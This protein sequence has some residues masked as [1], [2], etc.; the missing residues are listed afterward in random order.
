MKQSK[1][2]QCNEI[3]CCRSK[4]K[5]SSCR[6]QQDKRKG[7]SFYKHLMEW[8]QSSFFGQPGEDS[9]DATIL[10]SIIANL[11]KISCTLTRYRRHFSHFGLNGLQRLLPLPPSF[12]ALL[13]PPLGLPLVLRPLVG[14]TTGSPFSGPPSSGSPFPGS[15][16]SGSSFSGSPFPD[17]SFSG[18]GSWLFSGETVIGDGSLSAKGAG[19]RAVTLASA[20]VVVT[21]TIVVRVGGE[22]LTPAPA[23]GLSGAGPNIAG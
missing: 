9:L 23:A 3:T 14:F 10:P 15:S 5:V 12:P 21:V 19:D 13:P 7:L 17:S 6:G 20:G 18:G 16:F 1:R 4:N 22:E 11:P 2:P 8:L